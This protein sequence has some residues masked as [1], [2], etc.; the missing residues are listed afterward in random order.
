MGKDLMYSIYSELY[1]QK[2]L[3]NL[4]NEFEEEIPLPVI[5]HKLLEVHQ[6]RPQRTMSLTIA[7]T[8]DY[9][10]EL[11]EKQPRVCDKKHNTCV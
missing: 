3:S 8:R 5:V 6:L 11:Y 2:E 9:F 1:V 4:F 7:L 10:Y